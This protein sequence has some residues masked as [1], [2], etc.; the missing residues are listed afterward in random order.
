MKEVGYVTKSR[1][2]AL[3]LE[4]FTSAR[5]NDFITGPSGAI[6]MI[7]TIYE[8]SVVALLT[9][10]ARIKPGDE[11]T[12]GQRRLY[13]P[14]FKH[15]LGRIINPLGQ[16][17]DNKPSIRDRSIEVVIEKVADGINTRRPIN[18]QFVTG[19]TII[20]TLLPIARGQRQLILGEPRSGKNVFLQHI[21]AHQSKRKP[22]TIC[23]YAAIGKSEL[24]TRRFI[25]GIE[26]ADA[27]GNT[28]VVAAL[29]NDPAPLIAL[30]PAI[31]FAIADDIR[32][33]GNHVL[34][35]LDDIGKHARYLRE[36]TLLT[37]RPPGRELYP[38]DIFYQ[39]AHLYER[40]G[41]FEDAS[42]TVLPVFETTREN[43]TSF[44]A[45]NSMGST[46]GHLL[47]SSSLR[48][49]G[50]YPAIMIDHSV[51]RLGR[52]TQIVLLQ[53]LAGRLS[54]LL[55]EYR[56]LSTYTR[57]A[58]EIQKE[59]LNKG[60]IV[61][62]YLKQREEDDTELSVETILLTLPLTSFFDT[63]DVEFARKNREALRSVIAANESFIKLRSQLPNMSLNQLIQQLGTTQA[64]E[65][66]L[67]ECKK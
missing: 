20:D 14:S 31:A 39:H 61:N 38:G 6:A 24:E 11:F 25:S 10:N 51:T 37:N 15:L 40:G 46:D 66:L 12:L 13:I 35:I 28:V 4:G 65:T 55:S 5:L 27:L 32:K 57:F 30:T 33:Q 64:K 47:F 1:E 7:S 19:L 3:R 26:S 45:T 59:A 50:Y 58:S 63:K 56:Q 53:E 48:S 23:V 21:I 67:N 52:Q 2:Y 60:K 49:E 42:I 8:D 43:F 44:V 16:P 29:S 22:I 62:E 41:S 18:E 17:M 34:V 54:L 36:M 9:N